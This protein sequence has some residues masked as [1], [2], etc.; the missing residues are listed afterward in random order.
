MIEDATKIEYADDLAPV[1]SAND[2][3]TFVSYSN[4]NKQSIRVWLAQHILMLTLGKTQEEK[5]S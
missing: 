5:G 1:I 2:K 3:K 4:R